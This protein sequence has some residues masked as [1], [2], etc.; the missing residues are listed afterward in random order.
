MRE[1][2]SKIYDSITNSDIICA[3]K[4]LSAIEN[5][6]SLYS[7]LEE[8]EACLAEDSAKLEQIN[9]LIESV[10]GDYRTAQAFMDAGVDESRTED[11]LRITIA[12]E[13]SR[14]LKEVIEQDEAQKRDLT[15]TITYLELKKIKIQSQLP[16]TKE[17]EK[18]FID[19]ILNQ[20]EQMLA[21]SQSN[22]ASLKKSILESRK[23]PTDSQ[24]GEE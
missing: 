14:A 1:E 8:V 13:L 3:P 9:S 4:T 15:Q 6:L 10:S 22:L 17:E 7:Q 18:A 24:P 21:N 23:E 2:L 20:I 19:G 5:Y 11:S 16:R 12:S